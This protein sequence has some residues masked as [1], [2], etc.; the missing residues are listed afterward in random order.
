MTIPACQ[1]P[2]QT[3][4]PWAL[5]ILTNEQVPDVDSLQ[6]SSACSCQL[7]WYQGGESFYHSQFPIASKEPAAH[8]G[9][10]T[11]LHSSTHAV[12]TCRFDHDAAHHVDA[13][14]PECGNVCRSLHLI[15]CSVEH[16]NDVLLSVQLYSVCSPMSNLLVEHCQ[17]TDCSYTYQ[18]AAQLHS[19][20]GS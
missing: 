9:L 10:R 6:L 18:C 11:Q 5:M 13:Q 1:N 3:L 19:H 7:H 8:C 17:D 14:Y 15:S 16:S 2:C 20:H 4:R 12:H